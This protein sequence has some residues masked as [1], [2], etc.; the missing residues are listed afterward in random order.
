MSRPIPSVPGSGAA[1]LFAWRGW[2]MA[3]L[4]LAVAI[5]RVYSDAPLRPAALVLLLLGAAW[6]LQAG[7]YIPAHS[8]GLRMSAGPL[9]HAGPYAM[10]RHPLYLSNLVSAVG[11]LLFANCLPVWAMSFLFAA[12]CL[13]HHLLA[14]A[15]ERHMIGS[16]GDRYLGY[17]RDTPRWLGFPRGR[18]S[19]A[20]PGAG[21][22][23]FTSALRRQGGNVAKTAAAALIVSA[24]AGL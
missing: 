4:F 22:V 5:A 8:N 12:V 15:E 9:A 1:L 19:P 21:A 24:L 14:L 2:V 17:M 23:G 18:V 10:G 11:L 7:R 6:R 20:I 13:H 3:A 16:H